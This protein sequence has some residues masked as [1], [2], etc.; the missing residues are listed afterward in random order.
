MRFLNYHVYVGSLAQKL[1]IP[2]E[3]FEADDLNNWH[4]LR[5]AVMQSFTQ[6]P[7]PSFANQM[8]YALAPEEHAQMQPSPA[9]PHPTP[10]TIVGNALVGPVVPRDKLPSTSTSLREL[11]NYCLGAQ[12]GGQPLWQQGFWNLV[13]RNGQYDAGGRISNEAFEFYT[14][15]GAY[16]TVPAN[17]NAA[18][19]VADM[20]ADFATTPTYYALD[21]G[22]E[23]LCDA[24]ATA[25]TS[26]GVTIQTGSP[27][28]LLE[29][30]GGEYGLTLADG[31]LLGAG[32][33]I[34]ALPPRAL[35][36]MAGLSV[37]LQKIRDLLLQ[38]SPV[39]LFKIFLVYADQ[40]DTPWW[41]AFLPG[42]VADLPV[43]TRMTTDLPLRQSY[44]FGVWTDTASSTTYSLIQVSYSDGLRAGYWAGLLSAE[45]GQQINTDIFA[46]LSPMTGTENKGSGYAEWTDGSPL[47]GHPLFTVAHEQFVT[48]LQTIAAASKL[49]PADVGT[50]VAGAAIDWATDPFGGG[51][52]FWNVGADVQTAYAQVLN[53]T[54]MQP[55]G[56]PTGTGGL[57][58]VGEG[59]SLM[60]GWV[61]GAL[62]SV[63]D[64][65]AAAYGSQWSAPTWLLPGPIGPFPGE[66]AQTLRRHGR[67]ARLH[68]RSPV[69]G[70]DTMSDH[71]NAAGSGGNPGIP[72]PTRFVTVINEAIEHYPRHHGPRIQLAAWVANHIVAYL[73]L[74]AQ[75]PPPNHGAGGHGHHEGAVR[76][77]NLGEAVQRG[78]DECERSHQKIGP[79]CGDYVARSVI[80]WLQNTC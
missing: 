69:D 79:M 19:A 47:A 8:V 63:E 41:S 68:P 15:A 5:G 56:E 77:S 75:E 24:L 42:G 20:T 16:D 7:G 3:S 54:P 64:A 30:L 76:I 17:W 34:L 40:G 26:A 33:V 78:L 39:P 38:C 23:A 55:S 6:G 74:P 11:V 51:V 80:D 14:D 52:N 22:Y 13:V 29:E 71:Q 72:R 44:N 49:P 2:Y 12:A 57:F 36:L 35:Q 59:Y 37:P 10:G 60:Q 61:E 43:F 50:P 66:P 4:Y 58:I 73:D 18:T 70:G 21:A 62:W 46:D 28:T 25:L 1:A 32:N 53:P 27:V 31:T 67:G 48:F 9:D 45:T 65:L